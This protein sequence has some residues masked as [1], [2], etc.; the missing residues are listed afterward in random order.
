MRFESVTAHAFGMLVNKTLSLAP[1]LTVICGPNESGKSTWHAALYAGLCGVRRAKGPPT[2]EERDF[3][4]RHHPWNDDAWEVA[5]RLRLDDGRHVELRHNLATKTDCHA[6][7]VELGRDVAREVSVDGSIDGAVWLG[8]DRRSFLAVAC[9]GQADILGVLE[10]AEDLQ[11][12]LARAA[13]TARKDAT[14]AEAITRLEEYRDN[15][16]GTVRAWTKPL[17]RAQEAVQASEAGVESAQAQH[18]AF[19]ELMA[20]ANALGAKAEEL[21]AKRRLYEAAAAWRDAREWETRASRARELSSRFP[22]GAPVSLVEDNELARQVAAAISA[23]ESRPSAPELRGPT[24]EDLQKQLEALPSMPEG[25]HEPHADVKEARGSLED[26][27]RS[28]ALHDR[29]RPPAPVF[30]AAGGASDQELRDLARELEI[31][32]PTVDPDLQNRYERVRLRVSRLGVRRRLPILIVIGLLTVT[33]SAG[34]AASGLL[35]AGALIA[36]GGATLLVSLVAQAN[37]ALARGL[38]ELRNAENALGE[39]RHATAD[40][41][42]RKSEARSRAQMLGVAAEPAELRSLAEAVSTADQQ[43]RE[44]DGWTVRRQQ[45]VSEVDISARRLAAALG[46]RGISVA[47]DIETAWS[48]Y[49]AECAD[50]SRLATEAGRRSELTSRLAARQAAEEAQ[51]RRLDAERALRE[52]AAA[53]GVLGEDPDGSHRLLNA[54]QE[55]RRI[56][57]EQHQIALQEWSELQTLLGDRTLEALAEEARRRSEA[58]TAMAQGIDADQ[59]LELARTP[60]L[61]AEV[62]RIRRESGQA[63]READNAQGQLRERS[64]KLIDVSAAEEELQRAKDELDRVS[65]SQRTLD[66]TLEFLKEAQDRVHRTIAPLLAQTLT[67]FLP[68]VTGGRYSEALVDP[69]TLEVRV[70]VQDGKLRPAGLLSHGTAEQVYLL[71]RLALAQHLARPGET[72]PMILDDPTAHS[73]PVR[74][75]AIMRCLHT[76]SQ[77]QQVIVFSQEDEVLAWA[78]QHLL[79]GPHDSL[80]RLDG[81]ASPAP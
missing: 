51:R 73:D 74:T 30:P 40:A 55:R 17:R 24:M 56:A 13:A 1:G 26:S 80:E 8:L 21:Q 52:A 71:L 38:V 44:L 18:T 41:A 47:G 28:L 76:I 7:D 59:L 77:E 10:S 2:R 50:R 75:E 61:D 20:R 36:I 29:A 31:P 72:C 65:R 63:S 62:L 6:I 49:V 16:V 11:E 37:G 78:Q 79:D 67:R 27:T 69:E 46:T 15:F 42:R 32:E 57:L 39:S 66:F 54:W 45:L 35:L 58:A 43:Q 33:A 22:G 48:T 81:A 60:D 23:W 3:A 25:D 19:F 70:R 68:E 12:H 5:V 4:E 53:C 64:S 34:L 14:A 9:V